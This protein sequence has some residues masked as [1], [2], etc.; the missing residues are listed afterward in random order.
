MTVI[1][2]ADLIDSIAEVLQYISYYHPQDFIRAMAAAWAREQN[3]SAKQ[4]MA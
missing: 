2:E 4:A 1:L 3:P